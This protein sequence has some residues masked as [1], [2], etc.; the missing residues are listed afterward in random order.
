MI[1]KLIIILFFCFT[2]SYGMDWSEN[3]VLKFNSSSLK[4]YQNLLDY[5]NITIGDEFISST[6]NTNS[7]LLSSDIT[8]DN[9]YILSGAFVNIGRTD[10][11]GVSN[12]YVFMRIFDNDN[13]QMLQ[14]KTFYNTGSLELKNIFIK[15]ASLY[16]EIVGTDIQ[17]YSFGLVRK[18]LALLET[19]DLVIIPDT[20]FYEE[21][22]L[23]VDFNLHYP[24][25]V[26]II[27]FDKNGTIIDYICQKAYFH[28]G[29][30]SLSWNADS[31]RNKQLSSGTY[32]I[33]LKAR[34]LNG[35]EGE[36]IK[37][38]LFVKN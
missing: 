16:L 24:S 32:F 25:I 26:D 31:S 17:L 18:E 7:W 12:S 23:K 15:N 4:D 1:N 19:N 21:N 11:N 28:E 20:L 14:E 37:K 35:K 8:L 36:I 9:N 22:I 29:Q 38:L 2:F 30:N 10:E 34:T 5:E 27:L 3:N 13:G 33:Y 6:N